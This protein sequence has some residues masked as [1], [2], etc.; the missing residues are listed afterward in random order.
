MLLV[1]RVILPVFGIIILGYGMVALRILPVRLARL[2]SDFVNWIALPAILFRSISV[3]APHLGGRFGLLT[4]RGEPRTVGGVPVQHL[5]DG[6][7]LDRVDGER[8][9][10]TCGE[11]QLEDG[12]LGLLGAMRRIALQERHFPAEVFNDFFALC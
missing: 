1:A 9:S 12:A 7:V 10:K 4:V 5:L 2:I 11:I 6:L 3:N 8:A